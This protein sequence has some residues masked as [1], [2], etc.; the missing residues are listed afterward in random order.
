MEPRPQAARRPNAFEGLK[1]L[2]HPAGRK[3][4]PQRLMQSDLQQAETT[5]RPRRGLLQQMRIIKLTVKDYS[6]E[7][8]E[9][10]HWYSAAVKTKVNGY[11]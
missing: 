9:K 11:G 8:K 6:G 4:L 2:R 7:K 1:V 3:S 5:R 10:K